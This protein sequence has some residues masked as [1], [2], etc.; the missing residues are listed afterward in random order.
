VW[1]S[2]VGM[3]IVSEAFSALASGRECMWENNWH[4]CKRRWRGKFM[5]CVTSERYT[6]GTFN[7]ERELP[8][9]FVR[10]II[11]VWRYFEQRA[12][13][14]LGEGQINIV[15]RLAVI[16]EILISDFYWS[17]FL[18]IH[19]SV[20]EEEC[21]LRCDAVYSGRNLSIN[22]NRFIP[23]CTV[24]YRKIALFYLLVFINTYW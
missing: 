11:T 17:Q 16:Q 4:K 20:H 23:D 18:N 1:N 5:N 15:L 24:S 14:P 19:G 13:V 6:S 12:R 21:H 10:F 22:S 9:I 2:A 7:V 8:L 3:E